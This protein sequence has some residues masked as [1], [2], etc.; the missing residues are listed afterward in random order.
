[1]PAP[2]KNFALKTLPPKVPHRPSILLRPTHGIPCGILTDSA[3]PKTGKGKNLR[4]RPGDIVFLTTMASGKVH[5]YGETGELTT[6][7][8]VCWREGFQTPQQRERVARDLH[9]RHKNE[10]AAAVEEYRTE[11]RKWITERRVWE[12]TLALDLFLGEEKSVVWPTEMSEKDLVDFNSTLETP[13]DEAIVTTILNDMMP[14]KEDHEMDTTT[15]DWPESHTTTPSGTIPNMA[16]T[17]D[18]QPNSPKKP[19]AS[20]GKKRK[21]REDD[22]PLHPDLQAIII[23]NFLAVNA[24][25]DEDAQ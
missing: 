15:T 3:V 6:R 19:K 2:P 13:V 4:G 7:A 18:P 8:D 9:D 1:M 25:P 20:P 16:T 21:T 22:Q 5:I 10:K 14:D 24:T 23:P 17:M 11:I 12:Y